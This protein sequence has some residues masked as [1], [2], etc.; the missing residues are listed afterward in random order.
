MA[1]KSRSAQHRNPD[2]NNVRLLLSTDNLIHGQGSLKGTNPKKNFFAIL[3]S[4]TALEVISAR[5]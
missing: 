2:N 3:R 5:F 4:P 1:N